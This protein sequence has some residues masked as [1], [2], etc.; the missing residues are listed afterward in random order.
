MS[1][2]RGLGIGLLLAGVTAAAANDV[3][4]CLSQE[5]RRTAIATRQA[6][7][8]GRAM[9]VAKAHFGGE[10]VRAR[11]C[12]RDKALVYVLTI[13]AHDGKVTRAIIDGTSGAV[14][15]GR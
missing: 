8:L 11:L 15:H 4:G 13:L 1:L 9:E 6:I 5:Q 14:I 10:V 12:T 7:P 2:A 3:G